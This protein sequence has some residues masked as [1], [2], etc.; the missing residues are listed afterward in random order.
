[1]ELSVVNIGNSKGIRLS[2]TILEKY[3]IQDKIE[4]ILKKGFI[5]LKPKAEPRKGWE[6]AFKQ[7]NDNGDDQL[8]ID[9]VFDDENFD[10]WS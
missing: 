1:M 5:I 3:N 7:M 2:K 10:E 8:L 4:I 6:E 9:D